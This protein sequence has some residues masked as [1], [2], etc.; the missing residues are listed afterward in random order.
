[1]NIVHIGGCNT[2]AEIKHITELRDAGHDYYV[3]GDSTFEQ[4][5][6]RIMDADE[7]HIWDINREFE[8][9]LVFFFSVH[10]L[11]HKLHWRIKIFDKVKGPYN[12]LFHKIVRDHAAK[13]AEFVKSIAIGETVFVPVKAET[14]LRVDELETVVNIK[15]GRFKLACDEAKGSCEDCAVEEECQRMKIRLEAA[16]EKHDNLME[17]DDGS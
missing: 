11:H 13:R 7:I 15:D 9:G 14:R 3:P 2:Q 6:R 16:A 1:M 4:T 17:A 5:V 10:A 12:D 8:L